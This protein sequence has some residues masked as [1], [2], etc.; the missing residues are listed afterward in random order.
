MS[1]EHAC[2]PLLLS[3]PGVACLLEVLELTPFAGASGSPAGRALQHDKQTYAAPCCDTK[4]LP[5]PTGSLPLH[6]AM[7]CNTPC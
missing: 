3:L 4:V 7:V 6:V 5:L 1:R 2:C